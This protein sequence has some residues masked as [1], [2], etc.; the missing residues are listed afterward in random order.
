[1][2]R[3]AGYSFVGIVLTMPDL[4][5]PVFQAH[6]HLQH[7]LPTLERLYFNTGPGTITGRT[8]NQGRNR[9]VS[10]H[11]WEGIFDDAISK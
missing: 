3:T 11:E 9:F 6:R 2:G 1:M 8:K 5:W 4:F 7:D 10:C